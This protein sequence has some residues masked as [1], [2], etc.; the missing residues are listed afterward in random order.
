LIIF[1]CKFQDL[2][3][4]FQGMSCSGIEH[5]SYTVQS[6]TSMFCFQYGCSLQEGWVS[7]CGRVAASMF[8]INILWQDP[9]EG[10]NHFVKH[11]LDAD[12]SVC[13]GNF[14][15]WLTLSHLHC[16]QRF[17]QHWTINCSML[18][19]T[20]FKRSTRLRFH[21]WTVFCLL[22]QT[23]QP[24][25]IWRSKRNSYRRKYRLSSVLCFCHQ[26]IQYSVVKYRET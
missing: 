3:F 10:I 20:L 17:S 5:R 1:M 24:C 18:K 7:A 12:L 25:K 16:T 11:A 8:L 22:A 13:Q 14:S 19:W 21:S 26:C 9:Q 23:W 2:K 15:W 4:L 6:F